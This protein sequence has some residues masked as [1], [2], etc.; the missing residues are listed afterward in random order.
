VI[1]VAER[2]AAVVA[3]IRAGRVQ[4][5]VDDPFI[6]RTLLDRIR[7]PQPVVD[8][9]AIYAGL[10]AREQVNLYDD[11]PSCVSPWDDA[12]LA[13]VNHHG[14][15]LAM[16]VHQ[17]PWGDIQR[18]E[19]QNPVDWDRVRWYVETS[20]WVG[21]RDGT[22][23]PCPTS[24]PVHLL[25]AAV[26]EDG[27]PADLHWTA[28]TGKRNDGIWEMPQAVLNAALNFLG[29]SNVEV[30]LPRHPYPVRR[31]M[32][33]SKV[34]VQ[35]IVVR[36]PGKRTAGGVRPVGDGDT[37]LTSV[38]GHFAHYGPAHD[39]GLLFGKLAGKFW[40]PARAVGGFGG[41]YVLR[42]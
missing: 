16:Q 19:S 42:P 26:H 24:G 25:Q 18:W 8:V 10:L 22:G 7:A 40:I 1:C 2:I 21:G 11:F 20:L 4:H 5:K 27:R 14:N 23:K 6:N 30:A 31:R 38:R 28:L 29:C 34:E 41:D 3:D 13:Y 36:P 9:T 37:P 35:A 15:I 32:R 39:R 17:N 12:I 33:Q